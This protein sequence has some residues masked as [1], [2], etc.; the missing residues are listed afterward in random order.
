MRLHPLLWSA[1]IGIAVGI[2]VGIAFYVALRLFGYHLNPYL[3]V[4]FVVICI[5]GYVTLSF[6]LEGDTR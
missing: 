6:M 5:P 3:L 4:A 1:L 2:V